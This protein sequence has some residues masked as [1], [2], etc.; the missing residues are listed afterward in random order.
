MLPPSPIGPVPQPVQFTM[1]DVVR[2]LRS[3]P[4]GTAPGLS[5]LRANHLREAVF[6][7][8]QGCATYALQ[9]LCNFINC[10][11]TGQVPSAVAPLL[12]GANLF[13]CKKK[14]GGLCPIAVGE[15]FR[16]LTSKCISRAVQAQAI[17]MLSPLQLGVGVPVGCEAIVHSVLFL[18]IR[19]YI[20]MLVGHCSLISQMRLILSV[21]KCC[22]GK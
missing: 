16:R 19:E 11:S 8:S 4:N 6:C 3:F 7:R 9:K 14:G 1:K 12:C 18:K 2:A 20:Q 13:A 21:M 22:S 10:L 15:V 5:S 17:G